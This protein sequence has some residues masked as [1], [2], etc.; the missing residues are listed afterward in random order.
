[1]TQLQFSKYTHILERDDT[2]AFY[3][4]LHKI[5]VFADREFAGPLE[6]F[7][8]SCEKEEFLAGLNRR[9]DRRLFAA[10]IDSLQSEGILI[11]DPR[12]DD[13]EESAQLEKISTPSIDIAF[14]LL[15]SE[16]NFACKYCF[17]RDSLPEDHQQIYMT[18]ETAQKGLDLYT[19]L[20][21]RNPENLKREKALVFYGGEPLMNQPVL[22]FSI[23]KAAEYRHSGKLPAHLKFLMVTN[24]SFMTEEIADFLKKHD[25]TVTFSLD[26]REPDNRHRI[27]LNGKPAYP[28]IRR[29]L[30]ICQEKGLDIN[31]ACTLTPQNIAHPDETIRSFTDGYRVKRLGFNMLLDNGIMEVSPDYNRAASEFIIRAHKVFRERGIRENRITRKLNAFHG[32]DVY[33]YDCMAAAGREMVITPGGEIGICHEHMWDSQHSISHVNDTKF[34]PADNEVYLEWV[35]RTPLNMEQCQDCI[36][37]GI[38]GGGCLVNAEHRGSIWETDERFCTQSKTILNWLIWESYDAATGGQK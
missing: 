6:V 36:A 22:K 34:D 14:F 20:I 27:F 7:R 37:L 24:G 15:T 3:H 2:A 5:P 12:I 35:Q 32:N 8:E 1:M 28:A 18:E 11:S 13:K 21:H 10:L 16:C 19:R 33:M 31:I 25:V 4:A 29:G 26:G 23:E 38:C 30:R 9:G 17:V